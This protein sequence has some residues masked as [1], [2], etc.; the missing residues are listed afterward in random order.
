VFSLMHFGS[1]D[2]MSMSH[3]NFNLIFLSFTLSAFS[4]WHPWKKPQ[5]I[6]PEGDFTVSTGVYK[7][8]QDSVI[9]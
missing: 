3:K 7:R 2:T 9:Q 4:T 1:H 5:S 6:P 8:Y